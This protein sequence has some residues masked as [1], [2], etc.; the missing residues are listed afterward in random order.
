MKI[1]K[2]KIYIS[3]LILGF[4]CFLLYYT[5]IRAQEA[6]TTPTNAT[7]TAY[8]PTISTTTPQ[9]ISNRFPKDIIFGRAMWYGKTFHGRKMANGKKFDMF[10]PKLVAH[11]TLPLGT[12]IKVIN[13]KTGKSIDAVVSDRGPYS[14]NKTSKKYLAE[15]DLSY[16][17]AKILGIDKAGIAD[18]KIK[19]Y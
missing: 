19:V 15:I 12:E 8:T 9:I 5:Q 16:A 1:N 6:T 10:D 14:K 4:C 7:T 18:V 3:S 13:V 17:G 2:H 11:R